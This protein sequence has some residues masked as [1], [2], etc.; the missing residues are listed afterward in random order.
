MRKLR[1]IFLFAG[2]MALTVGCAKVERAHAT[3]PAFEVEESIAVEKASELETETNT[4]EETK[5]RELTNTATMEML[6]EKNGDVSQYSYLSSLELEDGLMLSIP[7]AGMES[8][9][10][11]VLEVTKDGVCLELAVNPYIRAGKENTP[12][13]ESLRELVEGSYNT[14]AHPDYK[15]VTIGSMEDISVEGARTVVSYVDASD[16]KAKAYDSTWYLIDL[17]EE[18]TLLLHVDVCYSDVTANTE[19]LIAELED[20]YEIEIQYEKSGAQEKAAQYDD[21]SMVPTKTF[22]QGTISFEL[23]ENWKIDSAYSNNTSTNYSPSNV[24]GSAY[25]IMVSQQTFSAPADKSIYFEKEALIEAVMMQ[26]TGSAASD[27]VIDDAGQT[28]LGDSVLV[29]FKISF[30]GLSQR[31]IAYYG[32]KGNQVNMVA[33]YGIGTHYDTMCEILDDIMD[34]GRCN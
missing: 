20:Y 26:M 12:V 7:K 22:T 16:K 2:V 3:Q 18:Q 21:N 4:Q 31:Y 23:P 13:Y 11:N 27:L 25:G 1:G 33:A 29:S 8:M 10:D 9:Q 19:N 15:E 14:S 30:R 5:T 6:L 32:I 24:D 17:N 34:N 28:F